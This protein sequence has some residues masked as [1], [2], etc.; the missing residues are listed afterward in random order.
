M[1]SVQLAITSR[2]ADLENA[3]QNYLSKPAGQRLPQDHLAMMLAADRMVG[4]MAATRELQADWTRMNLTMQ[5]HDYNKYLY[6]TKMPD[7][8]K[9]N[10]ISRL[11]KTVKFG[12][13]KVKK[14]QI[15][16]LLL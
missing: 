12:G 3:V 11:L 1:V 2:R 15:Y 8:E 14:L 9:K 16:W 4:D 7:D 13:K 6:N 10:L 5:E